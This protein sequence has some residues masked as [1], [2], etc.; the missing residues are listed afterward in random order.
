MSTSAPHR[1]PIC[2]HGQ[3]RPGTVSVT[4]DRPNGPTVVF[5]GV[6]ALVCDNCGQQ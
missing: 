3:M 6:P 5:K 2:K 1:C 4:L